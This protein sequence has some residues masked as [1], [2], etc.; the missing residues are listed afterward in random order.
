MKKNALWLGAI[1]ILVIIFGTIYTIVQQAQRSDADYP[2]VQMAEDAAAALNN[3]AQ[4]MTLVGSKV[5]INTS[6]APFTIIYD[7]SGHIVAGSGFL[8]SSV[9][10]IAFG[11]LSAANGHTY[12][13]VTWQPQNGVR[14]ASVSVAAKHYYVLSGRSLAEVEKNE[15]KSFQLSVLGGVCSLIVLGLA[16]L[17]TKKPYKK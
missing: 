17:T 3:G 12:N 15:T 14:I 5:N 11:V 2:Q 8:N 13:R 1:A 4:P 6:L 10:T 7:K 9:P 16:F